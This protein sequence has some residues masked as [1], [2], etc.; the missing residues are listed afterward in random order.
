M[1]MIEDLPTQHKVAAIDAEIG[2]GDRLD[3]GDHTVGTHS[4]RVVAEV[5]L[6]G[7]EARGLAAPL[8]HI[9]E[10]GQAHVSE[11]VAVIREEDLFILEVLLHGNQALPDIGRQAGVHERDIPVTDVAV[12]K[13]HSL[14]AIREREV[15]RDALVVLEKV[16]FDDIRDY[17]L[18]YNECVSNDFTLSNGGKAVKLYNSDIDDWN[19]TFV[20]TGETSNIGQRLMAVQKYLE[21]EEIFL[22]NYSDGLT[23]MSLPEFIDMVERSGKTARFLAVKPNLSYHAVTLGPDGVVTD[24]QAIADTDFRVNG[25]R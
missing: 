22:A 14:A 12:V 15:V 1:D 16:V 11:A 8:E 9:D 21:D 5:R 17:F 18:Q 4:D 7:E 10:L 2:I 6:Y 23:D 20:D 24:I 19:I 25:C 3:V 13:L